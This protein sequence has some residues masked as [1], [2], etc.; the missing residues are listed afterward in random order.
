MLREIWA[1]RVRVQLGKRNRELALFNL[2]IDSK[3]RACDLIEL[4]VRDVSHGAAI[5]GRALSSCSKD[6]ASGSRKV[7]H[8][9]QTK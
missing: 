8:R 5:A 9:S 2:G 6:A 1:I 3:L 4:R 7:A